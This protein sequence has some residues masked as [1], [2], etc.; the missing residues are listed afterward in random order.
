MYIRTV[1]KHFLD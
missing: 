1:L